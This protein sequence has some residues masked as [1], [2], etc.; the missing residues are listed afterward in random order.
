MVQ[1]SLMAPVGVYGQSTFA[2]IERSVGWNNLGPEQVSDPD[3]PPD[4]IAAAIVAAIRELSP[5][6]LVGREVT[7]QP[8]PIGVKI[9]EYCLCDEPWDRV[10]HALFADTD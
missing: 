3:A 1:L 2:V 4:E 5:Y 10:F 8:L 9:Y 7:D 6:R